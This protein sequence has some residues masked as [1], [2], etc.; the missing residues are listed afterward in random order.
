MGNN[1]VNQKDHDPKRERA[2][3]AV[4]LRTTPR[5][6]LPRDTRKSIAEMS[7]RDGFSLIE[8]V[9]VLLILAVLAGGVVSMIDRGSLEINGRSIEHIA[10]EKSMRTIRD[11]IMGTNSKP[12][13][14][15]DLGQRPELFPQ[16]LSVLFL[17]EGSIRSVP[18]YSG[19]SS[20]DP[21]SRI[22]WRG[23][24]LLQAS[25]R[26]EL[27]NPTVLDAWGSPLVIQIG[28]LNGN[29]LL[30]DGD[31]R[32]ARLVSAGPDGV[33]DTMADD[34]WIPGDNSPT[35][36]I[37]LNECGDDLVLFFRVADTRK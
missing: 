15:A 37:S 14:W 3:L 24:Y 26:D 10:T 13:L 34:G 6:L 28:D 4:R 11:A 25:G 30:D 2:P 20:F 18:Q 23:P 27:G 1:R 29:S 12:G 22:G 16:S 8:L 9:V 7:G 5:G 36:E 33:L 19:V 32:Y 31:V 35:S 17:D 21:V